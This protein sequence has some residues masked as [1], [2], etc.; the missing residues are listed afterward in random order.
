MPSVQV[1]L[2]LFLVMLLCGL[3]AIARYQH[4]TLANR[5]DIAT[6]VSAFFQEP[7][8]CTATGDLEIV[9]FESRVFPVARSLRILLPRGYHRAVNRNRKYPVLYLNDGQDLFDVCTSLFNHEEWRVD[10]TVSHLVA[11]GTLAPLIVVGIDSAGKK[12]RPKEYLPYIDDTLTPPEPDPQGKLYPRFL[13][14]EVIP[15]VE[16]HYRVGPGP[17]NRVLGGSSYG[18]GIALYTMMVRPRSFRGLLLESPSIYADD[19]HLLKDARLV[20]SWPARIYI[21][22]G[23]VNEPVDDVMKL[24]RLF[25]T[26]GLEKERLRIVV[27]NGGKHSENWWAQRLPEALEFLFP[28]VKRTHRVGHP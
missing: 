16:S 2:L 12:L 22:T 5:A 23:T 6:P 17:H 20:R 15:F 18:A 26:A 24:K 19:Y 4:T 28:Y 11:S 9:R 27:Q 7:S 10:E 13:F 1:I 3:P 21:G 8:S 25:E 14:E